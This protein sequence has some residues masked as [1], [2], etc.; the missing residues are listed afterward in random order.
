VPRHSHA[1]VVHNDQLFL[2]GKGSLFFVFTCVR[3]DRL[4][5]C[6]CFFQWCFCVGVH[7]F[8][9]QRQCLG[10]LQTTSPECSRTLVSHTCILDR[11]PSVAY[12]MSLLRCAPTGCGNVL[13]LPAG[14]Y[15]YAA[16]RTIEVLAL[17]PEEPPTPT[18]TPTPTPGV[19]RK[20]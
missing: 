8:R 2:I 9:R 17:A 14:G 18:L 16:R 13:T 10:C 7:G 5:L 6:L 3:C 11:V 20:H 19:V 4:R 15:D 12:A 1:A